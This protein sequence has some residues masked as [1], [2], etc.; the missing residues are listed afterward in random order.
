MNQLLGGRYQFIRVLKSNAVGQTYLAEDTQ[1]E[2]PLPCIVKRLQIASRNPRTQRFVSVLLKKKA[3]T[4]SNFTCS[5][6]PKILDFF[7]EAAGFYII[8][9]YIEGRPLSD[10]FAQG[11]PWDEASVIQLLHDILSIVA[12]VHSWGVIHRCIEPAHLVRRESDQQWVL[13]GFGIFHEISTQVMRSQTPPS[14]PLLAESS[15]YRP[16]EQTQGQLQFSSDIYAVGMIG[17]Q[18]ITGL[19]SLD[20]MKLR[21]SSTATNGSTSPRLLWRDQATLSDALAE[22]LDRMVCPAVHQRYQ[23]VSDV[24]NDLQRLRRQE[25]HHGAIAQLGSEAAERSSRTSMTSMSWM[26]PVGLGIIAILGVGA[27]MY[28]QIPQRWLAQRSLQRAANYQQSGATDE[29]LAQ[30]EQAIT[31]QPSG[32]AFY[33]RGL[34][35]QSL[36]NTQAALADLSQAIRLN[37]NNGTFHYQRGNIRF[38]LGDS[39]GAIADYTTA[40]QKDPNNSNAY[41][42]RGSVRADL[43]DD[44]GA[45]A[46]YTEALQVDP[47][48]AA[49]YLNRCLSRSNVGDHQAAIADCSQAIRLQPNSV[50]AYQNRGLVRRRIGDTRGAIEDFNIAI[51]LD[52]LDADPYYNR[53]LARYELGDRMGAIADYTEAIQRN[54]NHVFAYY[55]RA[56]LHATEDNITAAL[57]DFQQAA[58]LCLDAGR[59]RCYEDAQYQISQLQNPD[60]SNP[61]PAQEPI[62]LDQD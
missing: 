54:P 51:R 19:S 56:R 46:D 62:N 59:T 10:M 3:E 13:I 42:N 31:L 61:I 52:P 27:L 12:I 15:V 7:E 29:A 35:H 16:T 2:Q 57:D 21:D 45:I 22:I 33:E 17:I 41:V 18:A 53:G 44:Q 26:R 34:L 48:L 38:G 28:S 14:S 49:A 4:L 50:F 25:T 9:E 11:R 24:L 6:V 39:E 37:P 55:D 43:G 60:A 47:N 32:Q 36:G 40:I 30:Y 23:L 8:E 58:K 20:L 1:G 5:Q